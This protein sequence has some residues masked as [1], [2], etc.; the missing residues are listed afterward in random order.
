MNFTTTF[1]NHFTILIP[2]IFLVTVFFM[3]YMLIFICDYL[4]LHFVY[5]KND[6]KINIIHILI[7]NQKNLLIIFLILIF[8]KINVHIYNNYNL[9]VLSIFLIIVIFV[10]LILIKK[11][12]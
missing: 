11:M 4:K 10:I 12:N 2:E 7:A 9:Y 6:I 1:L 3:H 8:L 5:Y